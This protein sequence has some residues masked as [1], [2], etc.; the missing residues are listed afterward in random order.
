M[1][2]VE[3]PVDYEDLHVAAALCVKYGIFTD[4]DREGCVTSFTDEF[5][6]YLYICGMEKLNLPELF[7]QFS[8]MKA[9]EA[10]KELYKGDDFEDGGNT[11]LSLSLVAVHLARNEYIDKTNGDELM[12]MACAVE[13]F[14]ESLLEDKQSEM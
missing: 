10:Y 1:E 4:Y 12:S 8:I 2:V 6:N 7:F 5:R 3:A 9:Y 14:I 13:C 11:F